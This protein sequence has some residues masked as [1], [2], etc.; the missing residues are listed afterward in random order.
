MPAAAVMGAIST[1]IVAI[2][3]SRVAIHNR[4][5]SPAG[6]RPH[7]NGASFRSWRYGFF[8]ISKLPAI[9]FMGLFKSWQ[10][11]RFSRK[12]CVAEIRVLK[13]VKGIDSLPPIE[14]EQFAQQR[15]G[16]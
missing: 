8:L 13:S 7:P 14:L 12:W 4:F 9:Q 15:N 10:V 11:A 3:I 2:A 1:M 16:A 5:S 6:N